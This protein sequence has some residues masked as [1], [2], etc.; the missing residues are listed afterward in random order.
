MED[1]AERTPDNRRRAMEHADR[2]VVENATLQQE[3]QGALLGM[4]LK[5]G[6][7]VRRFERRRRRVGFDYSCRRLLDE[8]RLSRSLLLLLANEVS[9]RGRPH[10]VR[11]VTAQA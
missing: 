10:A 11:R 8:V 1:A 9:G 2:S 6:D 5:F 3:L 7:A 4:A